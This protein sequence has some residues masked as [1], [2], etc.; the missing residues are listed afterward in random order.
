VKVASCERA[1]R[2][3]HCRVTS[4]PIS[5]VKLLLPVTTLFSFTLGA[6][7]CGALRVLGAH[8]RCCLHLLVLSLVRSVSIRQGGR[9]CL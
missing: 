5:D 3:A 1:K 9:V 2:V 8:L 7:S 6:I 4:E